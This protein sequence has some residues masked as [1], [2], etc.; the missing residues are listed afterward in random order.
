MQIPFI[1]PL[2]HS[3]RCTMVLLA[4]AALLSGCA[5]VTTPTGPPAGLTAAEQAA[6]RTYHDAI[7]LG[8]R[9]SLR[10]QQNGFDQA[11][12]GNFTWQQS[13]ERTLVTLSSPLGQTMATIEITPGLSTLIQAGQAPRSATDVDALAASALGWPLPISGLRDWLQ[14][15]GTD[16]NGR[17]FIAVPQAKAAGTTTLD[18]W[19][20]NYAS[21]QN[22]DPPLA[23]SHPKRIDLE[24]STEHAGDVALRIVIDDWQPL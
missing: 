15:F 3:A 18:G 2:P 7:V 17:R 9:L 12:H 23:S 4:L 8:G 19:R 21:W 14:G 6:R 24:R 22:D 13:P 16:A 20:I 5:T 10:Y 1:K 11:V